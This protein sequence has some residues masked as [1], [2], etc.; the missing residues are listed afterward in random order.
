MTIVEQCEL[1]RCFPPLIAQGFGAFGPPLAAQVLA[2]LAA[3][4]GRP[5]GL[6]LAE[7]RALARG[8]AR[9]ATAELARDE[10]T[11][12]DPAPRR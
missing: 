12:G 6:R 4:N 5:A 3:S 10:V 2:R 11:T 9:R 1:P 7:V 8:Y